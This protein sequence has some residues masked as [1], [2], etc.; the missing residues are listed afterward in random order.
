L[1]N[2]KKLHILI[3]IESFFDGGAEMFAIRLANELSLNQQVYFI[4][5]YPYLSKEKRQLSLLDTTRIRLIQPGKNFIGLWL[6]KNSPN[7]YGDNTTKRKVAQLYRFFKRLQVKLFI[8][9]NRITV[10]NSHSW[11]SD[12][13]FAFLKKELKFNLVVS[14]HGHYEFLADKR[15]NYT[16]LTSA[17]LN[18]VD[19]VIYTSPKQKK[20]LDKYCLEPAKIKKIFYGVSMP[21][22]KKITRYQ[23]GNCLNL[24]MAARGIKEKGWEEAI[25]AVLQVQ[26]KY[27]GFVKLNLVGEGECIDY[28]KIKYHSPAIFFLGY[29][30]N[31]IDIVCASHIGLLPTY[32]IAESLPNTIIEYLFCG[33]PVITTNVGAIREMISINE[34]MAGACIN[35][36]DMDNSVD[37]IAIA[38][39][40]YINNPALI[41]KH[42]VISL[43]AAEKFAMKNCIEKYLNVFTQ[44]PNSNS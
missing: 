26:R 16:A 23:I 3:S 12:V 39:E 20:T 35:L 44:V 29:Q 36:Q 24:V 31:V 14:L 37:A 7:Q 1:V 33:K 34:E 11:D 4:E 38:I 2:E 42:S 9:K 19:T 10:V 43:Q 41:E 5:V 18:A 13:F 28:L 22:E 6:Y 21:L 8:K 40:N 27:P 32:Y 30:S 17:T 25:L 15:K